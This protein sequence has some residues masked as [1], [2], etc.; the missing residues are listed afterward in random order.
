M[1]RIVDVD[2]HP[3]VGTS[4]SGELGR[5]KTVSRGRD[6]IAPQRGAERSLGDGEHG[7]SWKG[8]YR[9]AVLRSS[10]QDRQ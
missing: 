3:V 9:P 1:V 7:R 5:V 4:E 2:V 10:E 6:G 8:V